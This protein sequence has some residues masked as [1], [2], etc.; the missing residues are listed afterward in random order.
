MKQHYWLIYFQ[1]GDERGEPDLNRNPKVFV[2]HLPQDVSKERLSQFFT[3]EAMK[4]DENCS[5]L[6][7][8]LNKSRNFAFVTF[9][10]PAVAHE[11]LEYVKFNVVAIK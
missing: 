11:M 9:S 3:N 7:V 8:Y 5:V 2:N 6:D 1:P 4:L 10:S